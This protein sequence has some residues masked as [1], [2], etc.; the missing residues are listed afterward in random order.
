VVIYS[1]IRMQAYALNACSSGEISNTVIMSIGNISHLVLS[2]FS[3]V[4]HAA[5]FFVIPFNF[6]SFSHHSMYFSQTLV[7]IMCLKLFRK[8]AILLLFQFFVC[9][10]ICALVCPMMISISSWCVV[11]LYFKYTCCKDNTETIETQQFSSTI[12]NTW[13]PMFGQNMQETFKLLKLKCI[14]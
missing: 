5:H 11:C 8:T 4:L 9:S 7:F 3:A 12:L 6:K 13:W 2:Q 10:H 14:L 1:C